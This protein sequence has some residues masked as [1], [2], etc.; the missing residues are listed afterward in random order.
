MLL[1]LAYQMSDSGSGGDNQS[2]HRWLKYRTLLLNF[3]LEFFF[4]FFLVSF[5][6]KTPAAVPA[7]SSRISLDV[8]Q[9]DD[10][11]P[12]SGGHPSDRR[13]EDRGHI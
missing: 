12:Q 3:V 6:K 11:T 9:R 1:Q 10:A 2:V 5:K 7:D 13:K 8:R 4:F